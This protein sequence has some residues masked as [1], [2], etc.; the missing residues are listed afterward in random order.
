[1]EELLRQLSEASGLIGNTNLKDKF[2]E[3]SKL[4]KRG[5]IF[6]ASLYL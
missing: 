5:I 2:E 3:A 4:L 6:A 1:L